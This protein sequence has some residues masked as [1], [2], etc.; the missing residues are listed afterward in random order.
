M[1][2]HPEGLTLSE[3]LVQRKEREQPPVEELF[4]ICFL[5][6][7]NV[8]SNRFAPIDIERQHTVKLFYSIR[9]KKSSMSIKH[10]RLSES[11]FLLWISGG[12]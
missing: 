9:I 4:L 5:L 10:P 3:G 11:V 8:I 1:M 2:N 12:C 6:E 7:F